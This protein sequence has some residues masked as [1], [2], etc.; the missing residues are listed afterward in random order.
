[1]IKTF[2]IVYILLGIYLIT[3]IPAIIRYFKKLKKEVKEI[4]VDEVHL[5]SEG[6]DENG[7]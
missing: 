5:E 3:K 1:M 4:E 7:I 2:Q 6:G